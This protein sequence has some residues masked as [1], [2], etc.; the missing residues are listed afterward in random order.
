MPR[1]RW[2]RGS[3]RG[4]SWRS[5]RGGHGGC[6][7]CRGRNRRGGHQGGDSDERLAHVVEQLDGPASDVDVAV[8]GPGMRAG[9]GVEV[10]DGVAGVEG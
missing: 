6:G 8:E 2:G 10:V 1:G 4:G 7:R 3:R 5:G 9:E